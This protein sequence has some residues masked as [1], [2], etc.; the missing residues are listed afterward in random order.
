MCW[1]YG[2]VPSSFS[3]E[4]RWEKGAVK[5]LPG[6]VS[7]GSPCLIS[8]VG[9]AQPHPGPLLY[10][11]HCLLSL[12]QQPVQ[13]PEAFTT[14]PLRQFPQPCFV[15]SVHLLRMCLSNWSET[16]LGLNMRTYLKRQNKEAKGARWPWL[17][18]QGKQSGSPQT[19]TWES[20]LDLPQGL[21]AK[22]PYLLCSHHA[23]RLT[24][25]EVGD[26]FGNERTVDKKWQVRLILFL[27]K[28][29]RNF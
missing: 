27:V 13:K 3:R 9:S 18:Q 8:H 21:K 16:H 17:L 24:L 29:C 14:M 6:E 7:P 12:Q 1:D 11:E 19:S 22:L 5:E 25:E 23:D 15:P 28:S 10:W 20:V 2:C 4:F 26:E